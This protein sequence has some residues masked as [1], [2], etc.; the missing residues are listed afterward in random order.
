MTIPD[1]DKRKM[2][3]WVRQCIECEL[4]SPAPE[5]PDFA[6]YPPCGAFVTLRK[7][8]NLRGCIGY[9][10]SSDPLEITL[11]DAAR[12]AAFQDPRFPPLQKE[13]LDQIDLEIS[14]L[15]PPEKIASPE[16]LEM[17]VHGAMIRSGFSSGLFLPQV[18]AEQGWNLQQFMTHLCLKAG[19]PQDYW[20]AGRY[21]L[22]RFT[23]IILNEKEDC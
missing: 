22:F 15:T 20:K 19:L 14:L 9:T 2:L 7:N 12:S 17:G 23:A 10:V 5:T 4:G 1:T 13:E 16:E 3:R 21:D 8:G 11:Q 6:D 18:A